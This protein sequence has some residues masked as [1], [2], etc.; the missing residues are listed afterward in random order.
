[1]LSSS[2]ATLSV[3]FRIVSIDSLLVQ[4]ASVNAPPVLVATPHSSTPSPPRMLAR[5]VP[6]RL[7]VW[8]LGGGEVWIE[9]IDGGAYEGAADGETELGSPVL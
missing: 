1:M 7:K 3:R 5:G 4:L 2:L 9:R 8:K 6:S